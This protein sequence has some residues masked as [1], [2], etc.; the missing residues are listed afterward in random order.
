ML[1]SLHLKRTRRQLLSLN[2]WKLRAVFWLCAIAIGAV[3]ALFS[4]AGAFTDGVFHRI[5]LQSPLLAYAITP[6][7][8][9][10]IAWLTRTYMAGTEGSGIPQMIAALSSSNKKL[11][12][13]LLSMRIALG[14]I[15]LTCAGLLSGASIGTVGPTIH[16]GASMMYAVRKYFPVRDLDM[17][18][19]LIMAGGAAGISAAFNNPLA[20]ILFAIEE[21]RKN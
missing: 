15:F 5:Y 16:V 1:K 2:K 19:V 7:G 17:H 14:K 9:A 20:G 21:L 6:I 3:A 11:H 13:A 12:A 4:V 10:L 8:L 18:R